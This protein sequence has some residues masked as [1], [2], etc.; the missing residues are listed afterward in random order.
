MQGRLRH[1]DLSVKVNSECHHY[2]T[3]IVLAVDREMHVQVETPGAA[4]LVFVPDVALF[5]VKAPS[6]IDDF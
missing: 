1:E 2:S 3:P 5:D 6:I 4:P